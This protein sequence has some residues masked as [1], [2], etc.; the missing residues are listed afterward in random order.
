MNTES[1]ALSST[2]PYLL[3]SLVP[4]LVDTSFAAD[5]RLDTSTNTPSFVSTVNLSFNRAQPRDQAGHDASS[6]RCRVGM[7][8]GWK[9]ALPAQKPASTC[10]GAN[11]D[12]AVSQDSNI[13]PRLSLKRSRAVARAPAFS[14]APPPSAPNSRRALA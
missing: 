9:Q 7:R 3:L 10:R 2:E 12:L 11:N 14:L 1:Q 4:F 8:Q 13:S 6:Q 5:V